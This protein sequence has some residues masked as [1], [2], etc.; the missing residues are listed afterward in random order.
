MM[1]IISAFSSISHHRARNSNS[2][3]GYCFICGLSY[4]GDNVYSL[5]HC[6]LQAGEGTEGLLIN[7]RLLLLLLSTNFSPGLF[8]PEGMR[9]CNSAHHGQ[10]FHGSSWD[11]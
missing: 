6:I 10:L 3:L 5:E 8:I 4:E 9:T 2:Y 11:R 7:A 1:V